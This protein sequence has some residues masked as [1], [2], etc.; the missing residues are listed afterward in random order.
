MRARVE[1][2]FTRPVRQLRS[3]VVTLPVNYPPWID[4]PVSMVPARKWDRWMRERCNKEKLKV[5]GD[6]VAKRFGLPR[7]SMRSTTIT[8][9]YRCFLRVYEGE[10]TPAE[11]RLFKRVQAYVEKH[12]PRSSS[13]E[14]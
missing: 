11:R 3:V 5:F 4:L 2:S 9:R 8:P 1:P 13:R 6:K 14:L 12:A 10:G 7:P